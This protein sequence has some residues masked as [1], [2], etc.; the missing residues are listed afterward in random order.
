[1]SVVL[2][3]WACDNFLQNKKVSTKGEKRAERKDQKEERNHCTKKNNVDHIY[4]H[5]KL[6][7]CI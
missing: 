5:I 7:R 1:M 2:S 4:N 3:T 6:Y